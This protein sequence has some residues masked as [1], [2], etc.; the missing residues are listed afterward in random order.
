MNKMTPL[1]IDLEKTIP[2]GRRFTPYDMYRAMVHRWS[3]TIPPAVLRKKLSVMIA[4]MAGKYGPLVRDGAAM[5]H[6]PSVRPRPQPRP[7]PLQPQPAPYSDAPAREARKAAYTKIF[8]KISWENAYIS[9]YSLFKQGLVNSTSYGDTVI[10]ALCDQGRLVRV[11]R[12]YYALKGSK[13]DPS[14]RRRGPSKTPIDPF[15]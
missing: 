7:Q 14:T 9:P 6:R 12:G 2:P 13:F 11:K 10:A 4:N 3:D 5:Y 8:D 15:S 1:R